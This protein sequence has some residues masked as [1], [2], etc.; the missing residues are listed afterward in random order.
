MKFLVDEN[1]GRSIVRHLRSLGHDV[2]S[3][4][5]CCPGIEDLEVCVRANREGRIIVTIDKDF[6]KLIFQERLPNRGVILLRLRD[7]R[8]INKVRAISKLL[9]SYEERLLDHF[10]VVSE[11]GIRIRPLS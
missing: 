9:T 8:A 7:E 2:V 3:I 5:E 4:Q 10:I 1:A 11:T 6:G